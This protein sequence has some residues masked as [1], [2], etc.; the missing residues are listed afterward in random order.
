MSHLVF[1]Q[2]VLAQVG[3]AV[4]SGR[5]MFLMATPATVRPRW[6]RPWRRFCRAQ[7]SFPIRWRRI[8]VL[9]RYSICTTMC[10]WRLGQRGWGE[11]KLAWREAL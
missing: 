2:R 10:L 5:A 3:P 4:N 11:V 6:P 7:F 8:P 9:S 1:A